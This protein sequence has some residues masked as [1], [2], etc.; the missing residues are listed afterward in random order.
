[1]QQQASCSLLFCS[2]GAHLHDGNAVAA[3]KSSDTV[4]MNSGTLDARDYAFPATGMNVRELRKRAH[5]R[6]VVRRCT[7]VQS[8]RE[9]K[10]PCLQLPA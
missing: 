8:D 9:A 6:K 10:A 2:A 1:M 5:A 3:I 4:Q 7:L